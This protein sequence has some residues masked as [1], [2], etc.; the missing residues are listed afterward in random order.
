M[1]LDF[2]FPTNEIV[3]GIIDEIP[4]DPEQSSVLNSSSLEQG[5]KM[6]SE[7]SSSTDIVVD[8]V[9]GF[10]SI[11]ILYGAIMGLAAGLYHA[12]PFK[13]L[14][15]IATAITT[16][17]TGGLLGLGISLFFLSIYTNP[18]SISY[19]LGIVLGFLL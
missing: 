18:P 15:H 19:L 4:S 7:S 11:T 16:I 17:T 10:S 5:L 9:N 12:T 8:L 13:K 3:K 14:E 6:S 2:E 1:I